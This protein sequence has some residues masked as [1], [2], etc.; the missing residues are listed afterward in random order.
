MELLLVLLMELL[1]VLVVVVQPILQE[2]QE[3]ETLVDI[4]HQKEILVELG[5]AVQELA[6]VVAAE[7]VNLVSMELDQVV[8]LAVMDLQ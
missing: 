1:E 8:D 3:L 7:L 4:H 2:L 6:L 5:L